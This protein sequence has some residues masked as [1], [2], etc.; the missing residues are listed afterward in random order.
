MIGGA[1]TYLHAVLQDEIL[2]GF[3]QTF[4]DIYSLE[5]LYKT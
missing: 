4:I 5:H 2:P 3:P 1:K